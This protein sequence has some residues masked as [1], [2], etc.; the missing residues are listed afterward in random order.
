[1]H[2]KRFCIQLTEPLKIILWKRIPIPDEQ[3]LHLVF[4]TL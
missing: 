4:V 1:M 2:K 3:N